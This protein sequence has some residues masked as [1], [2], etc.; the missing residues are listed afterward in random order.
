M[1]VL[2]S[3]YDIIRGNEELAV[4]R[5]R[6]EWLTHLPAGVELKRGKVFVDALKTGGYY[7]E[8]GRLRKEMSPEEAFVQ[9][10]MGQM[11]AGAVEYRKMHEELGKLMPYTYIEYDEYFGQRVRK[12]EYILIKEKIIS[13]IEEKGHKN[14]SQVK[15]DKELVKMIT[16][17]NKQ[18]TERLKELMKKRNEALEEK[19]TTKEWLRNKKLVTIQPTDISRWMETKVR[20]ESI[21]SFERRL[22]R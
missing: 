15:K 2:E 8:T 12:S 20:G 11:T 18:A 6:K 21:T 4:E 16:A 13:T 10:F 17:Y 3:F 7:S 5:F 22:G 19:F 14:I 9:L 1:L